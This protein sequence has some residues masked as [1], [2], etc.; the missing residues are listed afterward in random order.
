MSS[1]MFAAARFSDLPELRDL[2]DMFYGRYGNS[3]ELFASQEVNSI[4]THLGRSYICSCF[5]TSE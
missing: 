1:I 5:S 2:R 3:V 4:N